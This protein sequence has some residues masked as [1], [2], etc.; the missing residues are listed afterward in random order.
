[1]TEGNRYRKKVVSSK[2][3]LRKS[4]TRCW[5]SNSICSTYRGNCSRYKKQSLT[6]DIEAQVM[7]NSAYS[8]KQESFVVQ[9]LRKNNQYRLELL[10]KENTDVERC[11]AQKCIS[12][13][14]L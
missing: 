10:E 1:M 13:V 11:L 2:Q 9:W 4:L 5:R 7:D 12:A 6:N 8:Y 14:V 3:G